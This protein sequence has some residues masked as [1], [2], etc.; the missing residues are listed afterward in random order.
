MPEVGVE[1]TIPFGIRILSPLRI[2]VP[3]LGHSIYSTSSRTKNCASGG[4]GTFVPRKA[5]K[6]L[7]AHSG[8]EERRGRE[9]NP[10]VE[11]LQT[12]AVP[13]SYRAI[14]CFPNPILYS[15]LATSIRPRRAF[16]CTP[17]LATAPLLVSYARNSAFAKRISHT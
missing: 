7:F 1:P 5:I 16:D 4:P 6:M 9:S 8:T 12:S 2:P 3:P 17:H 10:R 15:A 13:L 11:V 14:L